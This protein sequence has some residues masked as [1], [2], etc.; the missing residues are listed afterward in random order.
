MIKICPSC[1]KQF[2]AHHRKQICC[3]IP[4]H[5]LRI[6]KVEE[7]NFTPPNGFFLIKYKNIKNQYYIN[8]DGAIWSKYTGKFL[9][10]RPDK[11][12]YL[13]VSIKLK[14]NKSSFVSVATLVLCTFY[15]PPPI[16]MQDPTV[17]HKDGNQLNNSSENLEWMERGQNSSIRFNKGAGTS[18]HEAKLSEVEVLEIV[19]LI[20]TTNMTIAE[21]SKIFSVD[22]STINNILQGKNWRCIITEDLSIY[23]ETR[24]NPTTG[25]FYAINPILDK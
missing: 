14:G 20:K 25:R 18:N 6:E 15:G 9:T 22:K 3:S 17:N 10:S 12:G 24:R 16:D 23:R 13:R 1:H 19:H 2:N 4:C 5:C 7:N 11:D 21:I 8:T